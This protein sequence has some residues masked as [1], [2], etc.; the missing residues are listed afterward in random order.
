M[1]SNANV[2]P[3]TDPTTTVYSVGS[4]DSVSGN[5]D[6]YVAY[7][8]AEIPGYSKFGSYEG[9]GST[10]GPYVHCGFA[11]RWCI[12][13]RLGTSNWYIWDT[14]REP[15]NLNNSPLQVNDAGTEPANYDNFLDF[16]SNGFKLRSSNAGTNSDGDT[17]IFMAFA[18]QPSGTIFG[19]N[20]NA[21]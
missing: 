16:L 4:H 13:K 1:R 11:P 20:A 10:N 5:S 21:R 3:D 8:W 7:C 15:N 18:E 19:R 9:N 17:Y 6:T 12:T 2:Y 14:A